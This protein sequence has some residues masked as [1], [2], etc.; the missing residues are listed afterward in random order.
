ML[1]AQT[2]RKVVVTL[3]TLPQIA[4][5][6]SILKNIC[7]LSCSRDIRLKLRSRS[8]KSPWIGPETVVVR[9]EK[10]RTGAMVPRDGLE[11][12]TN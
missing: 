5:D 8:Q 10:S 11:P 2:A 1:L 7:L 12:S 4:R 9:R 6:G 3:E